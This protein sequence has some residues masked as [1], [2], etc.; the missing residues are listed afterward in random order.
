MGRCWRCCVLK[1]LEE[2]GTLAHGGSL[3]HFGSLT[4]LSDAWHMA[5]DTR[6]AHC[7]VRRARRAVQSPAPPPPPCKEEDMP[8]FASTRSLSFTVPAQHPCPPARPPASLRDFRRVQSGAPR[9]APRRR[10]GQA[11]RR[12]A[13]DVCHAPAPSVA[14][15]GPA[16]RGRGPSP[17]QV[18]PLLSAC[19][20]STVLELTLKVRRVRLLAVL[21]ESKAEDPA[22]GPRSLKPVIR[23][24]A[25]AP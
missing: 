5:C 20:S 24:P 11:P 10:R 2:A 1:K 25:V 22:A 6:Q 23:L 12:R 13:P 17:A 21:S 19:R 15:R 4:R 14:S 7:Q 9:R 8:A 3:T 18:P 16:Q